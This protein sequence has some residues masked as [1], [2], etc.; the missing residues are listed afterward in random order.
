MTRYNND[1]YNKFYNQNI[2]SISTLAKYHYYFI[3]DKKLYDFEDFL[4]ECLIMIWMHIEKYGLFSVKI[5]NI[6]KRTVINLNKER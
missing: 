6:I 2:K 3:E 1:T 5:N 4:Q